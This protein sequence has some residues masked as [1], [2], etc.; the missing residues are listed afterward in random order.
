MEKLLNFEPFWNIGLFLFHAQ[1]GQHERLID[2]SFCLL[3]FLL[4]RSF[5]EI[6]DDKNFDHVRIVI[7]FFL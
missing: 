3:S 4:L 6:S 5:Y 2:L 7:I 1:N